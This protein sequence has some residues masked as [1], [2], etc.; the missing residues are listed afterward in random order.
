M[1]IQPVKALC[2]IALGVLLL[3]V[4]PSWALTA[5][6]VARLLAF[7][8][9]GNDNFGQSVAVDGDTAVI[10]AHGDDDNGEG[11]GSAYVFTRSGGTWSEYQKLTASDGDVYDHFGGSVAMDGNTDIIS[12]H[13][14]DDN[15]EGSGSAYVFTRSGGTWSEQAKLLASD[16]YTGDWF[17]SSVA[18]DGN[19]AIVGAPNDD[20][21]GSQSGSAYIFTRS[22]TTWS[23]QAKLLASDGAGGDFFGRSVVVDGDTAVIGAQEDGQ[24]GSAYVFTRLGGTWS[25]Q[26]KLLASDGDTRDWF[27][28][29]VAVDGD[30]AIVGAHGDDDNGEDSG[31][32]Y[33]FTRSGGTW[34]EQAKLLVSDGA[35]DDFFGWLVA[36][37]GDT[38]IIGAPND[39]DNG[40][41]SGSAY[42]F[43]RSGG[44]WEK[45]AK[46]LASDGDV[47]DHFGQSVAVDGDTVIIGDD[48]D[49]YSGSAYVF[50]LSVEVIPGDFNGDGD[51][52]QDDLDI[53]LDEISNPPPHDPSFDLNGDGVVDIADA[54]Y[55]VVNLCTRPRCATE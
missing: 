28:S 4:S 12:A 40:S 5:Q 38:A 32:A 33:V 35:A 8:G 7:D 54:R 24:S 42:V 41:Y 13:G 1:K 26:A 39:D 48:N 27:G 50:S 22:G 15:G 11:S 25:E 43:T 16:G 53:L 20:D 23:E 47:A 18:V 55:L 21:D 34:S 36:I 2:L 19:T 14:D 6:E 31:S 51:I 9:A 3:V 10:G 30:T 46:L 52:D 45:Q 49:G 37:D 17:G 29:S 44:T